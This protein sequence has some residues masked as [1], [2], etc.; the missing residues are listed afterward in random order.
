MNLTKKEKFVHLLFLSLLLAAGVIVLC[1]SE[2]GVQCH[3]GWPFNAGQE[4][5]A[6]LEVGSAFIQPSYP[7]HPVQRI[8]CVELQQ[9]NNNEN[10]MLSHKW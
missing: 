10:N 2:C 1:L 5:N 6:F 4:S 3:T 7:P 9:L 8:M